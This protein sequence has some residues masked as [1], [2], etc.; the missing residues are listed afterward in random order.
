MSDL[1]VFRSTKDHFVRH[2]PQSP[3]TGAQRATFT[4]LSYFNEEPSLRFTL[5]VQPFP[6]QDNIEIQT[7][8]GG[9]ASFVKWAKIEF[10]VDGA[11][12]EPTVYKDGTDGSF[13][14]PFADSTSGDETYGSGRYVEPK[15]QSDVSLLVDFN[16]AYNP[17]CAYNEEWAC[18]ITPAE[19]RL[20]VP[21]RAGEKKF[22]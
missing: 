17:Y 16:Y 7:T 12:A 8:T 6:E 13:F 3:L 10:S 4:G 2:D 9:V 20:R 22:E 14:L 21:I 18:P 15:A 19:N 11:T 5:Q 1:A